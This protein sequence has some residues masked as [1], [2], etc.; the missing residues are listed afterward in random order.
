M[1]H[2]QQ[3][4]R[5]QFTPDSFDT[6]GNLRVGIVQQI[7]KPPKFFRRQLNRLG[8]LKPKPMYRIGQGL[9][10]IPIGMA[11]SNAEADLMVNVIINGFVSES[12]EKAPVS[13]T[14]QRS[15]KD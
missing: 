10:G 7:T 14:L 2:I 8:V 15:R 4:P 11:M 3:I 6:Q 12:A 9:T 1:T 5:S 13:I